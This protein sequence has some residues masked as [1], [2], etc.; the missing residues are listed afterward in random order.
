VSAHSINPPD[1]LPPESRPGVPSRVPLAGA[2]GSEAL[3]LS[4]DGNGAVVQSQAGHH[5]GDG[6]GTRD[7]DALWNGLLVSAGVGY[8]AFALCFQI[9]SP[10]FVLFFTFAAGYAVIA[11]HWNRRRRGR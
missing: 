4:R 3:I 8:V 2:R 6:P 1:L 7:T 11:P 10:I 5:A 9:D